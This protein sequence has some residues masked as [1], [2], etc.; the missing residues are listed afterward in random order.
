MRRPTLRLVAVLAATAVVVASC[1][2]SPSA[3]HKRQSPGAAEAAKPQKR[4]IAGTYSNG[5]SITGNT[6]A[7]VTLPGGQAILG[8]PATTAPGATTTT[9]VVQA[10]GTN[11]I[12]GATTVTA[13]HFVVS[14]TGK[15]RGRHMNP[16]ISKFRPVASAAGA[17]VTIVGKRLRNATTVSFDG[18]VATIVSNS[19]SRIRAI[20]P[21]GATSGP[22][23]VVTPFG[24]ATAQGFVVS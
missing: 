6:G 17:T 20:V 15:V 12:T 18:I 16:V 2:T 7:P 10:I 9:G 8:V 21:G 22:I 19:S 1:S 5:G 13:P 4:Y 11:P 23:S 14:K 24:T 3:A